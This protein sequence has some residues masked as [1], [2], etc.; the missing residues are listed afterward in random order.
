MKYSNK[1]R[2]PSSSGA[3]LL[4]MID[5]FALALMLSLAKSQSLIDRVTLATVM[6]RLGVASSTVEPG[7]QVAIRGDGQVLYQGDPIA[8]EDVPN[9]VKAAANETQPIL[10][11]VETDGEGRGHTQ[12]LFR[13]QRSL[14][15]AG[16]AN[17]VEAL[18]KP[19]S[20]K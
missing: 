6:D 1:R 20:T 11:S 9:R 10:V 4:P 16:V 14:A 13:L 5:M 15:E 18:V 12:N 2:V 8:L 17:P 3:L 19:E 7:I